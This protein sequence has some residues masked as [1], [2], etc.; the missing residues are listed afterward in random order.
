MHKLESA[1]KTKHSTMSKN[2][3]IILIVIADLIMLFFGLDLFN[4][5]NTTTNT[6]GAIIA[7]TLLAL[8][9][10]VFKPLINHEKDN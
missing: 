5:A 3:K 6:I 2:I 10:L 8:N 4:Q 9:Y 7:L 1:I